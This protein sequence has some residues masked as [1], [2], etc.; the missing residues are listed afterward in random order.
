MTR[1]RSSSLSIVFLL[2]LAIAINA[3]VF[4][5]AY[6]ML[7]KPL[8]YAGQDDLVQLTARSTKMGIDL[9]WSTPYLVRIASHSRQLES[10]AGYQRKEVALADS[11]GRVTGV[12]EILTAEPALFSL[13]RVRPEV[14]RVLS[15]DDAKPGADPVAL[16]GADLWQ[17]RFGKSA[18]VLEQKVHLGGKSYRIVGVLPRSFVFPTQSIQIWLPMGFSES[19]IAVENAGSFGSLRAIA[20]LAPSGTL[21]GATSEMAGLAGSDETL[22]WVADQIGLKLA[23]QPLRDLWLEDRESSLKTMLVASLL[24]FGVTLANVY[25]LYMLRMLRRRQEFALLAAVGATSTR[26]SAQITLEAGLLSAIAT[27][28][29]VVL[30]PLGIALLRHFDVMPTGTPQSIGVDGVTVAAIAAMCAVAAAFLA[31]SSLAFRHQQVFEVLRQTGN[32]QTAS[33]RVHRLRQALVVGQIAVTL[34][35]LFGTVLLA[36]SSHRL[37]AADVGFDRSGQLIGTL[38][39]LAAEPDAAPEQVRASIAAWMSVVAAMPDVEAV[40]LSSSAP[41]SENV[42]LEGF[43]GPEGSGALEDLPKAYVSYTSEDYLRAIGL[44][45]LEGRGFTSAEAEQRAPVVII[46]VDIADRYFPGGNPVGR[47]IRVSG[48]AD[49][50]LFPATVVGVVGRVR[51]RTLTARD[52]YPSIFLPSAVPFAVP[53]IPLNSVELVVR[54]A[55][56]ANTADAMRSR[57]GSAAPTLQLAEVVTMERRISD[58]IIDAMRLASLLK[59]LSAISLLLTAVGLYALLAHAVAMRHREFGIRQALGA[60]A[61]DLLVGVLSQGA[62]MMALAFAFGVPLALLLG[63]VLKPRLH[64]LSPADPASMLFVCALLFVVGL[65]ANALPAYRASRV[66]PMEALRTE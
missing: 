50:E 53:G 36:R 48:G 44:R 65:M 27:L 59:I 52:E 58:T 54:T 7:W 13:L 17:A 4:A 32:G 47:T 64:Q 24:V 22:A 23:A 28:V 63:A 14:G 21:G 37:L 12:T 3:C 41:F 42:T 66:R 55:Q 16:I 6:G 56:P 61:R 5:I 57:I 45:V 43:R 51:Q 9:G 2:A 38:Q 29:A 8:P 60:S 20:R 30:I 39:P 25:N 18:S 15:A 35:L 31:S 40:G 19:E 26:R 62:R 1:N 10:V 49:G 33:S 46:D 11:S 34:M